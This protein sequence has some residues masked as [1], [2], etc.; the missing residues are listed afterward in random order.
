MFTR[1]GHIV[2]ARGYDFRGLIVNDP[3]GEYFRSGYDTS[4]SGA[5]LRY[6]YGLIQETCAYDDQFWVHFVSK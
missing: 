6:S 5:A 2:V 3:H 4:V 1:S